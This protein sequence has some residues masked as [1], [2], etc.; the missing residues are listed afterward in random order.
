MSCSQTK[1][2]LCGPCLI[3]T[4]TA[5]AS[6]VNQMIHLKVDAKG[7]H[8]STRGHGSIQEKEEEEESSTSIQKDEQPCPAKSK[9]ARHFRPTC[10]L[11][12]R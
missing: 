1:A 8:S 7:F 11:H 10:I 5:H 12:E 9:E 4:T 2:C 6:V 3:A